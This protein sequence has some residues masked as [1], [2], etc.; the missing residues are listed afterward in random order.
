M[1]ISNKRAS[2]NVYYLFELEVVKISIVSGSTVHSFNVNKSVVK[3]NYSNPDNI[4]HN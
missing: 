1:S 3:T 4:I 2:D